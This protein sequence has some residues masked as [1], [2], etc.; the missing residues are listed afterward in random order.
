MSMEAA[1]VISMVDNEVIHW[2]L[3][4]GR[5]PYAIPDTRDLWDVIWDSRDTLLGVAHS[6]PGSGMPLPSSEDLTTFSAIEKALGRR[7][8]WWITSSDVFVEV[9]WAGE[10]RFDYKTKQVIPLPGQEAWVKKLREISYKNGG[11]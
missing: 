6:H 2:H 3:P 10:G 11:V 4:P 5:S 7:L 1:V 9:T 8:K